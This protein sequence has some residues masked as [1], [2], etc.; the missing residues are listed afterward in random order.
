VVLVDPLRRERL[1]A[2]GYDY[3]ERAK[4]RLES[5]NLCG[6]TELTTISHSDRYGFPASTDACRRCGLAF[7][8]PRLT[9]EEYGRFYD[10]IYRPL[11]SAFHGRLIDAESVEQDQVVYADALVETLAP[12][13]EHRRGAELLDVGGSTGLI[14]EALGRRFDL[15]GTVFDPA[16]AEVERAR[17]RGLEAFVGTVEEYQPGDRRFGVVIICQTIDHMLDISKALASVRA[18]LEPD[19][20]LFV[21]VVDFR[22]AYLRS[23]SV[24]AGTKIDHAYSLTEMSAE[25]YLARAGLK[26]VHKDYAA[27]HLHIGYVCEPAEPEPD[28]LP[29]RAAVDAFFEELRFVQNAPRPA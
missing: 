2:L 18:L 16:P 23:W 4:D 12:Y 29:D 24:E 22:A 5:C 17:A 1:A 19:G 7:L 28:V 6:S 11:V 27:D 9:V 26:P 10:G 21:D 14:T 25:T 3:A 15:R 20:L 8:N 13:L